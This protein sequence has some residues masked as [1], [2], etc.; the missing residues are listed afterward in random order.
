MTKIYLEVY[1]RKSTGLNWNRVKFDDDQFEQLTDFME[2]MFPGEEGFN[3]TL[4]EEDYK[5]KELN[6]L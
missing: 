1:V 4:E 5:I 3:F 6:P 2:E